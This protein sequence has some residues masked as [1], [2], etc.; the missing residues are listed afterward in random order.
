M[1]VGFKSLTGFCAKMRLTESKSK[2]ERKNTFEDR[3]LFIKFDYKTENVSF[4]LA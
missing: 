1:T 4:N 2:A 3:I